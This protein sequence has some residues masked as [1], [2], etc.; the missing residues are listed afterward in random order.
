MRDEI[1]IFLGVIGGIIGFIFVSMPA[2]HWLPFA[3]E[4]PNWMVKTPI[5]WT[6]MRSGPLIMASAIITVLLIFLVRFV[7]G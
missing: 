4:F 7:K 1:K 3:D 5:L 6:I 2:E